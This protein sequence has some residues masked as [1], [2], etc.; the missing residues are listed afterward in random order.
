MKLCFEIVIGAGLLASVWLWGYA[1]GRV[2]RAAEIREEARAMAEKWE[3]MAHHCDRA[4]VM[5]VA[6]G[7]RYCADGLTA[8]AN[9]WTTNRR[10]P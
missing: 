3:R 1:T 4:G 6:D 2:D 9:E 8:E 10:Q 5:D 7:L